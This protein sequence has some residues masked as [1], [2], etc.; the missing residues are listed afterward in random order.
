MSRYETLP[1]LV[2]ACPGHLG[3]GPGGGAG[4]RGEMTQREKMS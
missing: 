2:P 3:P 4:I 1:Q